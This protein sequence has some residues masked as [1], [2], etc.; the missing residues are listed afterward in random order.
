M[1]G[2]YDVMFLCTDNSVRSILAEALLNRIGGDRF[3]A[4]SAGSHPKGQVH[5]LAI[6][7]LQAQGFPT[8]TLRSKSWNEF[9]GAGAPK[10]DFIF[11]VCDSA[12]AESCPVWPGHPMTAHWG[13]PDPAA[14]EGTIEVR[15]KAF[16][17][18]FLAMQSR[19]RLFVSLQIAKL[20]RMSLKHELD[21]IGRT[22][23]A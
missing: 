10:M 18:A 20:D 8:E 23:D 9:D 5:P 6:E 3:V 2:P 13:I 17:D 11:T 21:A 14:V 19:I 22:T 7:L 16:R 1:A 4:H 15:R 12:T